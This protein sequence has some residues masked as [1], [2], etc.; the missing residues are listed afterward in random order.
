MDI[1]SSEKITKGKLG[2]KTFLYNPPEITEDSTVTYNEVKTSGMS[3]PALVYGG[4]E[5][6]TISF[7]I[8]L[9]DQKKQGATKDFIKHLDSYLPKERKSGYQFKAPKS[10]KF[11]FGWYVKTCR[12]QSMSK[13]IIAFSPKLTPIEAEIDVVLAVIG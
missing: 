13:R 4:G 3:Y 5:V 9:N 11:A 8:Y 2:G 7:T 10:L 12:L 1:V 6:K